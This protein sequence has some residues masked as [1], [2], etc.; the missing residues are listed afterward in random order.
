[1]WGDPIADLLGDQSADALFGMSRE[2]IAIRMA[3]QPTVI[4]RQR[5]AAV[6][7]SLA[8]TLQAYCIGS[9]LLPSD[10]D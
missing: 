9:E 8:T 2:Q 7:A 1:V 4:A 10:T 6:N 3:G 5:G